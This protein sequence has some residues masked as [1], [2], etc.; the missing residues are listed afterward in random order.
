MAKK[1][2]PKIDQ[3]LLKLAE[4]TSKEST[5]SSSSIEP[6]ILPLHDLPG[7]PD[8]PLC[9]GVGYLRLDVPVGH[10][11]FGKLRVCDCRQGQVNQLVRQRLFELSH[12]DELSHLTFENFQPRGRV[13]LLPKQAESLEAAFNQAQ[14]YARHLTG[15]LLFQGSY[16]CGKTHLAAAIANFAVS[17]GVPTLFIT[18]PDLLD[19]LRFAYHDPEATF[20]ERFEQIRSA[21]LLILDD[22]GTQNA[23]PW[24]Q[25]KLFQILNYRYI[26]K[27]PLVVTTNYLEQDLDDRIASRLGDPELVSRVRILATDYRNPTMEFGHSELSSLQSLPNLTFANFELRKNENL[28]PDLLAS[29]ENALKAAIEFA[30]NPRGWL[31]IIGPYGCGKTHLAA[32]IGHTREDKGDLPIMISVPDFLDHLRATF[33]PNSTVSLD[34]RFEEVRKASL[35]I[36]DDLGTQVAT[37][38]AKEKLFQLLNHRYDAELPTVITTATKL[39]EMEPRIRSR[40]QDRRLCRNVAITAPTYTGTAPKEVKHTH[41]RSRAK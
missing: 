7:D 4:N 12:L 30:N 24:A 9:H 29:L 28:S 16:G 35:L 25:E 37:P 11:E 21:P 26:N 1:K 23:T 2:S 15:W 27:L 5:P 36:L 17:I 41:P 10:P 33:S 13:G 6:A 19:T 38:W 14:Y 34:R 3:T 8:C 32:A 39:E 40:M 31:V 18:V 20:E 22:F